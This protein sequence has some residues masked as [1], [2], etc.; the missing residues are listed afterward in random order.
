M[1]IHCHNWK[2]PNM[3]TA[4]GIKTVCDLRRTAVAIASTPQDM[5][6][7]VCALRV[8]REGQQRG[9]NENT[10]HS[11]TWEMLGAVAPPQTN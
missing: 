6:C 10:I 2:S 11:W 1:T 7:S 8:L 5:T 9:L 3:V 4:D